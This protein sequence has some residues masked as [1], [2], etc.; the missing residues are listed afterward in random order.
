MCTDELPLSKQAFRL[1][2]DLHT[3]IGKAHAEGDVDLLDILDVLTHL[4][5]SYIG[6]IKRDDQRRVTADDMRRNLDAQLSHP[7]ADAEG[8]AKCVVN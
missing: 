8:P 2:E 1:A 7:V 3:R 4:A 6:C 5:A